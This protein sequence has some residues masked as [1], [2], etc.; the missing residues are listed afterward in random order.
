MSAARKRPVVGAR[1]AHGVVRDL[2]TGEAIKVPSPVQGMD[3]AAL[4]ETDRLNATLGAINEA[5]TPPWQCGDKIP[6]APARGPVLRFTPA[7]L[8]PDGQGGVKPEL[9]G[10]RCRTGARV[11]DVFDKMVDQARNA[12]AKEVKKMC[13]KAGPFEPPFTWGQV[14][15]A[16]DYA[17]LS[18]RVAASGVKCS[19]MESLSRSGSGGGREEA[20]FDDIARLRSLH[21]RIGDGLAAQLR[22][23]RPSK[24]SAG[25]DPRNSITSRCLVDQV[26]LSGQSIKEILLANAWSG[27]ASQIRDL[28][29]AL[30]ASLDRMQGFKPVKPQ[31]MG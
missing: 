5:A 29:S 17:A 31:N 11:R 30:C 8:V 2:E 16:R 1:D 23:H 13:E 28:R 10:Y 6:V 12:H 20:I 27:R 4:S 14:Q 24:S 18:E 22:R 15:A 19:S 26:C 3:P 25:P 7:E 21:R 9:M